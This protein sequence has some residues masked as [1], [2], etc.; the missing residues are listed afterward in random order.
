MVSNET[1]VVF[2]WIFSTYFESGPSARSLAP[3]FDQPNYKAT[4]KITVHHPADMI[5]LSNMPE[6]GF[7]IQPNGWATSYFPTTPIMSSYLIAV[8][9]GHFASLQT[10]SKTGVLVRTW[11]WTGMERYAETALR[12]AA[13]QVDFMSTYFKFPYMLPKLDVLALPQYTTMHGAEEHWG[14]IHILYRYMLADKAYATADDYAYIASITSHETVHQ[15][16]ERFLKAYSGF[17]TDSS[18]RTSKPVVPDKP[19]YFTGIPYNK[20]A[21]LLYMMS[22]A[23]GAPVFQEGLQTYLQAYQYKNVIPSNMFT[24]LTEVAFTLFIFVVVIFGSYSRIDRN[25]GMTVDHELATYPVLKETVDNDNNVVYSQEP[26]IKNTSAL[27]TSTYGWVW[28]IPVHSQMQGKPGR[29]LNYFVGK[30][31]G[32][33][34]LWKRTFDGNWQVDNAALGV[35]HL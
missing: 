11:A 15:K 33:N 5:A 32:S 28:N 26:F 25:Y 13:G 34:A 10:V 2:R 3:C 31:G 17:I 12:T 4:W 22:Q 35:C 7:T 21:T 18:T 24:H 23:L 19:L 30:D 14:F 9:A 8:A 29:V 27:Q 6:E 1:V 16:L 20:G